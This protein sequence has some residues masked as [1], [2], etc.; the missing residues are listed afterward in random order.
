[1]SEF[2][3]VGVGERGG[4]FCSLEPRVCEHSTPGVYFIFFSLF[5]LDENNDD[6]YE[7]EGGRR[8]KEKREERQ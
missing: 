7:E 2:L 5:D 4:G 6:G 8:R 1:M 3:V